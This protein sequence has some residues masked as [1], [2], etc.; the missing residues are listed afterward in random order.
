[1]ERSSS[2]HLHPFRVPRSASCANGTYA[3]A[4][5]SSPTEDD[6]EQPPTLGSP[7]RVQ[8]QSHHWI[9]AQRLRTR[10]ALHRSVAASGV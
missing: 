2:P 3:L 1:M 8:R 10:A 5:H 4:S 6:L 7:A 9:W